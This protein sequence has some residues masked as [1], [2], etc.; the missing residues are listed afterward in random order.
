MPGR[1]LPS[2]IFSLLGGLNTNFQPESVA[3]K[4]LLIAQ[5]V[6]GFTIFRGLG[7]V[8]GSS[9]KSADH[10]SAAVRDEDGNVSGTYV[11]PRR[12]AV[13][14]CGRYGAC[15]VD[16]SVAKPRT[17][18]VDEVTRHVHRSVRLDHQILIRRGLE[19]LADLGAG[20][21]RIG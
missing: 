1:N 17:E 14:E 5:N 4:G 7:K 16:F 6:D 13:R 9:R 15:G 19:D 12:G 18:A 8:P 21:L 10:G 11:N 2:H 20:E 3:G